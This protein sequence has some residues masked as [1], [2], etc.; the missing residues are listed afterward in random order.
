MAD[1]IRIEYRGCIIQFSENQSIWRSYD[2]DV[3]NVDLSKVK[4]AIDRILLKVRKDNATPVL[5]L[6]DEYSSNSKLSEGSI[7]EYIGECKSST[8]YGK[9]AKDVLD[10]KVAV[11][12][13]RGT[14][15]RE[16]R[17]TET[18]SKLVK[19]C[20]EAFEVLAKVNALESEIREMETKLRALRKTYPRLTVED[21]SALVKIA[22]TQSADD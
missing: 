13:K 3:E 15:E 17:R 6:A 22:D 12:G 2:L 20:P 14:N 11:V 1:P 16:S 7:I 18:L 9:N 19:K 5:F 10:H 21:I 8:G 4:A